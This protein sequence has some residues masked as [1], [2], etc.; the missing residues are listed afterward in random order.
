[1]FVITT[2]QGVHRCDPRSA[3]TFQLSKVLD[4]SQR[5]ETQRL[6]PYY[7]VSVDPDTEGGDGAVQLV[8]RMRESLSSF[9][10]IL[11]TVRGCPGLN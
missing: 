5:T 10:S 9:T 11:S 8:A 3:R 7:V 4:R 1:M 6:L 2:C